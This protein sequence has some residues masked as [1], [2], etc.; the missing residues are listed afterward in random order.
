MQL[1]RRMYRD[2]EELAGILG[3]PAGAV[4]LVL[5]QLAK[6]TPNGKFQTNTLA[7]QRQINETTNK[8]LQI[9]KG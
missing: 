4:D 6:R 9:P 1:R 2:A 7:A 3:V 5:F 8:M